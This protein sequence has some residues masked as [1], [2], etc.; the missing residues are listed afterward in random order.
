MRS[1]KA[2]LT[3]P[4]EIGTKGRALSAQSTKRKLIQ[5]TVSPASTEP[6]KPCS[7]PSKT[8]G[9]RTKPSEAPTSFIT[10]I[11]LRLAKMESLMALEIKSTLAI[12]IST[13]AP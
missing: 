4:V 5:I 1:K 6:T 8:N 10:S 2:V 7:N 12:K 13:V 11:S 9:V 3:A